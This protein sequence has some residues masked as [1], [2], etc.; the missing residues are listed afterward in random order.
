MIGKGHLNGGCHRVMD[1]VHARPL[2]EGALAL[3]LSD[4]FAWDPRLTL[5]L[6]GIYKTLPK[7]KI[8][9]G[10]DH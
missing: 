10:W 9:Q 2:H 8:Y 6:H 4:V 7:F 3:L 1:D 5:C